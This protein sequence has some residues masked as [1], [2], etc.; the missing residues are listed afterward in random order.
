MTL[1][2]LWQELDFGIRALIERRRC[3]QVGSIVENGD[4]IVES[5]GAEETRSGDAGND[6]DADSSLQGRHG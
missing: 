6:S 2:P 5:S 3:V 1:A 4:S